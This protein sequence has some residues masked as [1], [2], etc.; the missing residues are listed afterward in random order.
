MP[1]DA[2]IRG[3]SRVFRPTLPPYTTCRIKGVYLLV[4]R[5]SSVLTSVSSDALDAGAMPPTSLARL[6][7]SLVACEKSWARAPRANGCLMCHIRQIAIRQIAMDAGKASRYAKFVSRENRF[8][9]SPAGSPTRAK[10]SEFMSCAG[11]ADSSNHTF[12]G[13]RTTKPKMA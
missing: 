3:E 11:E 10:V 2:K 1:P 7:R 4:L 6:S 9:I 13:S 12:G 8:S 5:G